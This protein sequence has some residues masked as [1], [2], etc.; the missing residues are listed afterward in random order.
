MEDLLRVGKWS[1]PSDTMAVYTEIAP[2]KRWGIRVTLTEHSALVE[3]ID[4]ER[5]SWYRAPQR[6]AAYVH[7]PSLW[8]R[9]KG[10]TFEQKVMREVEKKKAVANEENASAIV[11]W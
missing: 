7:P 2:G 1:R 10:I 9:W 6:I 3:A 8:E 4:G 5:C 11:P